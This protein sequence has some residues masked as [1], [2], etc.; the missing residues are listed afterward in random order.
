MQFNR[1]VNRA[2]LDEAARVG[3]IGKADP[4]V[5]Q[6]WSG[7]AAEVPARRPGA[8]RRPATDRRTRRPRS[9]GAL[10]RS[11]ADLVSAAGGRDTIGRSAALPAARDHAAADGD[12]PRLGFAER[13]AAPDRRRRT[14]LYMNTATRPRTGTE[15]LDWV[16]VESHHGRIRC[17]LKTMDGCEPHTVW[18]W[19][20]IGKM[21]GAWGLDPLAA[22]A[23]HGFL[24]NHLISESLPRHEGQPASPTP[25]R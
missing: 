11:A 12:V 6:L 24:L 17:Q 18:T 14:I 21:S 23:T 9:A 20:A 3:F 10:V 13:V 4:I 2:Y 19:N 25:I 22:E 16:W 5:M 1:G 15:R 8:V 7:A